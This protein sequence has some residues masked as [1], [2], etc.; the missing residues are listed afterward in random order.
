MSL[1]LE[2][3]RGGWIHI[4]RGYSK[5]ESWLYCISF[6]IWTLFFSPA[7]YAEIVSLLWV[8]A[9]NIFP[10]SCALPNFLKWVRHLSSVF[11]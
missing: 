6:I 10:P 9:P 8:S 4:V 5:T 3:E 2:R 11:P 1:Q 7:L